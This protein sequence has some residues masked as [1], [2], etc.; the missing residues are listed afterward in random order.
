VQS[1]TGKALALY[2]DRHFLRQQHVVFPQNRRIADL[3]CS[4]TFSVAFSPKQP[5]IDRAKSQNVVIDLLILEM[6]MQDTWLKPRGL[7]KTQKKDND[8]VLAKLLSSMSAVHIQRL[9]GDISRCV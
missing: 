5:F 6:L 3:R 4:R 1:L 7:V 8:C 9:T 2:L